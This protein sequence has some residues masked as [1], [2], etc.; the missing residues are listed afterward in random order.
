M[1]ILIT[2]HFLGHGSDELGAKLMGS[3][4]RTLLVAEHKPDKIVFYNSGVKLLAPDSPVHDVLD[5]LERA[6]VRIVACG[7]CVGFFGLDELIPKPRVS[8][9]QEI[10]GILTTGDVVTV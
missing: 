3:F 2:S 10:V 1:T 4:L 9:M 7:T 5:E 6:G 8:N